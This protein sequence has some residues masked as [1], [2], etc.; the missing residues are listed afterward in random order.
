MRPKLGS[1]AAVAL[2]IGAVA[3]PVQP[4]AADVTI[5]VTTTTDGGPGSLRDAFDQANAAT[6]P[7]TIVLEGG[8]TYTLTV[9]GDGS[10]TNASGSLYYDGNQDLVVRTDDGTP[11]S[12]EQTCEDRVVYLD[13]VLQTTTFHDVVI[14][15]GR[16][17]GGAAGIFAFGGPLTL[18]RT[19]VTNNAT[20][21]DN[22]GGGVRGFDVTV[23]DSTISGNSAGAFGGGIANDG[24]VTIINST[25]AGN[26]AAEIGGGIGGGEVT[27]IFSTIVGNSAPVGANVHSD[28]ITAFGS[29]F[30]L[31]DGGGTDCFV[32]EGSTTS[33]CYN[34]ERRRQ[35]PAARHRRSIGWWRPTARPAGRQ[36]R[37]DPDASAPARQPA[38]RRD[39]GGRVHRR[40]DDRPA[41]RHSPPGSSVR[42]RRGGNRRHGRSATGTWRV[43]YPARRERRPTPLHWLTIRMAG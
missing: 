30:A 38:R 22:D 12:V 11:A 13:G 42:R 37:T 6:E 26:T 33:R 28:G 31:G 19:T 1:L 32:S 29:V 7:V 10:A 34:V 39:P 41:R 25:I 15:G 9:C 3:V 17:A 20:G 21:P 4:A 43:G 14:T 16:P 5:E 35:L 2:A 36:R 23:I 27:A 18:V 24:E 8:E 40:R